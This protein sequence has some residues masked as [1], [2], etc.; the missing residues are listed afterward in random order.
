MMK[1]L[2]IDEAGRGCVLGDLFVGGYCCT[3]EQLILI[4][5]AGATDSKKLSAKKR[6]RILGALQEIGVGAVI[7]ITPQ[8]IDAGNINTLE[9][10]AFAQLII[11][12]TPDKA[13]IDAPAHPKAIPAFQAR[14]CRRILEAGVKIPE[15]IIEPKADL[16]YP[17][18]GAASI[19]AKVLRDRAIAELGEVGSGY[20]SDPKT[21]AWLKGFFI[22]GEELPA[23][24]RTRWGTIAKLREEAKR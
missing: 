8:Q 10:E 22:R 17:V 4:K 11:T 3:E 16:N 14:L 23:S 2:G 24:V 12:H 21:R 7:K 13:Y 18:V 6:V 9:E 1:I 5:E 20:P 19:F 15:L